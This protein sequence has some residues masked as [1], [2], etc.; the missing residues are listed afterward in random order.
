MAMLARRRMGTPEAA[1]PSGSA[2]AFA[3]LYDRFAAPIYGYCLRRLGNPVAAEDA[4][5]LVFSRALAAGPRWD[6]PSL[7]SWLFSIA[8]NV[9][10]NA[11]RDEHAHAPLDA[12]VALID[13]RPA[14]D[15]A[16]VAAEERRALAA[17]L[18]RLPEDQRAVVELRL[19]GLRG[20]EI[21][22]A[23]GRSHAAVKM[24]QLRAYG[25]LRDLLTDSPDRIDS[26][27]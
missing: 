4:A 15:E 18:A 9:V 7:R 20:P 27:G 24:L 1:D 13:P 11:W 3:A 6:D 17:A 21:A 2:E 26:N 8:H 22:A 12:A 14:P 23:L 5:S 10:V 25:R 19:A 16:A